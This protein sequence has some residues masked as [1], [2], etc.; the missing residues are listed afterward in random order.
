MKIS[1]LIFGS[2][3]LWLTTTPPFAES[4]VGSTH[5]TTFTA[6]PSHPRIIVDAN[7]LANIKNY[8]QNNTQA[9]NYF[10]GLIAQGDVVLSLPPM[11]RP[12][13]NASDILS[14]AR[15]VLQRLYATALLYRI[16]GNV[17]YAERV[18]IELLNC[19]QWSDWDI[20]KHA[21]D[22]GEL[23]HATGIA[24]DW[25]YDYLA[26]QY[27]DSLQIIIDGIVNKGMVPFRQAYNNSV[28]G[29]WTNNPSNW[30]T[31]TNG[32][33]GIAALALLG[34]NN[35]P[36]WIES[37]ILPGAL[38][39]VKSSVSRPYT[40]DDGT[41]DGYQD[42][43]AWWEGS[44]YHGY[45]SR[46]FVPY[47]S[48]LETTLG[49]DQDLW[50]VPGAISS[51]HFQITCMDSAYN[52][53]NWADASQGQ[54]TLGMLLE[55]ARRSNDPAVA[56]TLRDRLDHN[57]PN[58]QSIDSGAD[59]M[60][61]AN[62]LIYFTDMGT[63]N[64]RLALP[65]DTAYPRKKLAYLRSSWLNT[66]SSIF[67]ATK[68]TNCTWNHGDL[69]AG[70]FV[71]SWNN[72]RWIVDLG[73]DNYGLPNYFGSPGE[74]YKYY[75]KNSLGHNTLKF[76]GLRQ[77]FSDCA[78]TSTTFLTSFSSNNGT[79]INDPSEPLPSPCRTPNTAGC[80][81]IDLTGAYLHNQTLAI[82]SV[83][84]E[85]SFNQDRSTVL[86][87]DRWILV[88]N[89]HDTSS[90]H[91]VSWVLH[92]YTAVKTGTNGVILSE[93]N[94]QVQIALAATSPCTSVQFLSFSVRLPPPQY[95]TNGLTR[96]EIVAD[97]TVCN[98]FDI[99][100]TPLGS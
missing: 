90:S 5:R 26:S 21:L 75:R 99:T 23:C 95:S 93:G 8:I 14:A 49:N 4:I 62:S 40:M 45:A 86:V 68:A 22:T 15:A 71:Y 33:A 37:E 12:P 1:L 58:P 94:S 97:P 65:L 18:R 66:N 17:T 38:A 80:T 54:E 100:I 50:E 42:D 20:G 91:N 36:P 81:G 84:R 85:I 30:A 60:E 59:Q 35:V 34:E 27:P 70:T 46:Y 10:Q 28:P 51:G 64:D 16:T 39:G 73:S 19:T 72:I 6:V 44:I 41:G 82:H 48:A 87:S 3:L 31:V 47:V 74:R 63:A 92:T 53:F 77:D 55:A 43:G 29:W 76:D 89:K 98:G 57:L 52:Y 24:M 13:E 88:S 7:R 61:Y 96:V 83:S 32:G 69:D 2:L 11:V 25:T 78:G 9:Q 56:W 67:V 79:V